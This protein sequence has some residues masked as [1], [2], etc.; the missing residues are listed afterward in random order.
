VSSEKISPFAPINN[1]DQVVIIGN[2]FELKGD[3]NGVGAA[4]ISGKIEGNVSASYVV[5]ESSGLIIGNITCAL[6]DISGHVRGS[7][8]S[9]DVIIRENATIEG[10]LTYSSLAIESGGVVTG[11]LKQAIAK[12]LDG[13]GSDQKNFQSPRAQPQ[14]LTHIVFPLDV[15]Q[16]LRSHASRMSAHLSLIDGSPIPSWIGLTQ[17]KLGLMVHSRE[18][19]QLVDSELKLDMR[20]HV[21]SQFFDFHLP[22]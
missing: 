7:I 10:D 4:I 19:Q 5:I 22:T 18:F 6:L 9:G 3:L 11:K 8:D 20:I 13:L 16:K 12:P 2:K 14:A 1:E 21:G 15:S 17:D